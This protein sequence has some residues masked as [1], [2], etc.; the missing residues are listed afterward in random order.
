MNK[1]TDIQNRNRK[2]LLL[3]SMLAI[4]YVTSAQNTDSSRAPFHLKTGVTVTNKGISL[5]PTFTLGKPAAIFDLSMGRKKLFFEPQLR[6]ALDGKPWSFIF[7]WRYKLVNREKLKIGI[8]AHPS[9]VFRNVTS[10]VNGTDTK[11][12]QVQRYFA[13]EFSPNYYV[14][15]NIS[16]GLYYLFSH[17]LDQGAVPYTHFITVNSHFSNIQ[18]GGDFFVR[19]H[20]QLYYLNQNN[21][22]GFY[23]TNTLTLGK[24]RFPL[25][26]QSI[27][28]Q[29]L[30]TNITA[31]RKFIW[32]LS[33]VYSHSSIFTNK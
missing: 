8:G 12:I 28:N 31:G 9:M 6:F 24:N 23:F 17:G 33:L 11:T 20:P 13:A 30:K 22:D 7:W 32:N 15:K 1:L 18:L 26:I 27:Q 2:I 19:L 25:S 5:L 16:L 14:A 10:S 29:P 4:T 3:I 21:S